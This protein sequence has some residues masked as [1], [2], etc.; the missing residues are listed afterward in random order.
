MKQE[1]LCS[2]CAADMKKAFPNPTPYPGEHVK[3]VAGKALQDYLC[4]SCGHP[5]APRQ[6]CTAFS[7][8]ADPQVCPE[9]EKRF[10]EVEP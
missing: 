8:W 6:D 4:D 7:I 1:I 3:F 9:W 5:I 2:V 10:I